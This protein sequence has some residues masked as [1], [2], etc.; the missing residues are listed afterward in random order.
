MSNE[1][2]PRKQRGCLFYGCLSLAILAFVIVLCVG[3]GIYFAKRTFDTLITDYTEANPAQIEEAPYPQPKL[4]ELQ[5]RL[6]AFQQGIERGNAA[7]PLEL[8]LSAE[9]LNALIAANPDLKGK[10]FITIDDDQIKGKVSV[11]LP[12]IGPFKLKG[13]YLNGSAAF[14]AALENGQLDVRLQQMTVKDKPLPPVFLNELKKQNL[15]QEAQN[16]PN[17]AKVI[18]KLESLEVRDGKVVIRGKGTQ[19]KPAPTNP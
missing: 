3:V 19:P 10:A 15:A 7:Q 6:N 16:D 18:D 4:Q 11:P 17:N 13:R 12:D 8:V 14:K 1:N 5:T 9:D 2:A